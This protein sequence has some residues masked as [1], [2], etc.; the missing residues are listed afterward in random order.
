MSATDPLARRVAV[1]GRVQGVFFRAST[2]RQARRHGV[3]GWVRNRPDGAV[4]A[5]LEG[6]AEDVATVEAW[7]RDGGPSSARVDDAISEDVDVDGHA[8]FRIRH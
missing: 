5:H 4:E 7:M 8:D 6:A 2:R 3:V 1:S